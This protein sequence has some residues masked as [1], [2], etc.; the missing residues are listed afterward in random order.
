MTHPT[1]IACLIALALAPGA[2][3][4]AQGH[5]DQGR[6]GHEASQRDGRW[7]PPG[8]QARR[9]QPKAH[10][11]RGHAYGHDKAHRGPRGAGPGAAFHRGD[12]VPM[13]YRGRQYVVEDWRQHRLR[14]PPRGH[15]WLQAGGDY[16]LVAIATGV[17]VDLLL[18]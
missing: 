12:R 3:A 14:P 11:G 8:H 16:M 2:A 18:H 15:H 5:S 9:G 1:F 10:P 13:A 7:A 4:L 17:I 6:R